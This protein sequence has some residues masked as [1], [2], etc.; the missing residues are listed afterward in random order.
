VNASGCDRQVGPLSRWL[1]I[2]S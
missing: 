1:A 2:P